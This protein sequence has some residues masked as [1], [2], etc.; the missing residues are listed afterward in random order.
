MLVISS[1]VLVTSSF[2]ANTLVVDAASNTP[3]NIQGASIL[4]GNTGVSGSFYVTLSPPSALASSYSLTL[5]PLPPQTNVMTLT[6]AGTMSSISYDQVGIDMSS[7]GANALAATRTRPNGGT[8]ATLGQVAIT[9]SCGPFTTTSTSFVPITNLNLSITISGK[10]ILLF[11]QNDGVGASGASLNTSGG[12][13]LIELMN[14]TNAATYTYEYE[15]SSAFTA[16]PFSLS[17]L[18]TSVIGI[19]GTYSYQVSIRNFGFAANIA[20]F[21]YVLVAYEIV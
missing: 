2:V 10:P 4:L 3:A 18:D 16:I 11:I 17:F 13:F 12:G 7:V 9:P 21:Y 8:S 15:Q 1:R 20:F 5:P 14:T 19:P 6:T